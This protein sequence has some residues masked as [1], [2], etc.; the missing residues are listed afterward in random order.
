MYTLFLHT[1]S[2]QPLITL[3]PAAREKYE[4]VS[5]VHSHNCYFLCLNALIVIDL[6]AEVFLIE[7][8]CRGEILVPINDDNDDVDGP[9]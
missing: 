5:C 4:Y 6:L 3:E 8:E 9:L 1:R 7:S 2:A